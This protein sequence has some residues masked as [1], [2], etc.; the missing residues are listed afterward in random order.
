MPRKPSGPREGDEFGFDPAA[1]MRAMVKR[2]VNPPERDGRLVQIAQAGKVPHIT[3]HKKRL[4]D[5]SVSIR[6]DEPDELLFQHTVLTQTCLPAKEQPSDVL[7]WQRQQGRAVLLIEAGKAWN[8]D[9]SAFV[10]LGLPFGAQ[11]RL[12]LMHLNSEA[13]RRGT[14]HIPVGDSLTG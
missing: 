6:A 14:P 11:A 13:M 7:V 8:P 5:A 1:E 10:Q 4:I 9:I 3:P 2:M 12:I